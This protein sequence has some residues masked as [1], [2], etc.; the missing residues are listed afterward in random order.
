MD[1]RPKIIKNNKFDLLFCQK[2][3]LVISVFIQNEKSNVR[4]GIQ[5]SA[6]D[7]FNWWGEPDADESFERVER[8]LKK[9]KIKL[10]RRKFLTRFWK[11]RNRNRHRNWKTFVK[12]TLVTP[13]IL[14]E[15]VFHNDVSNYEYLSWAELEPG[16]SNAELFL[17]RAQLGKFSSISAS[18][19][20]EL[21]WVRWA[22]FDF[23]LS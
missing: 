10:F 20:L 14:D 12:T 3:E 1:R 9:Y 11:F 19:E 21:S 4:G 8:I 6:S 15:L 18:V 7:R 23:E 2:L 16:L 22:V 13:L 5:N 17:K